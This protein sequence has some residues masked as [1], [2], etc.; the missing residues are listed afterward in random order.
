[1]A[2]EIP[3][4]IDIEKAFQDAASKIPQSIKPLQTMMDQNALSIRLHIDGSHKMM[5]KDIL[6]NATLSAS[7]LKTA[8]SDISAK[9]AKMAA[10]GGFDLTKGLKYSEKV[11]LQAYSA[12]ENK[13][14]G[15]TDA[16]KVMEK[17]YAA[18]IDKS[19]QKITQ[20]T[21]EIDKL[22]LKLNRQYKLSATKDSLIGGRAVENTKNKIALANAELTKTK[23]T[24]SSLSV[25][26]DKIS[27]G[28]SRATTSMAM[29]RT[30]AMQM[31]EEW[32]RGATYVE[33]YNA[34]LGV[35]NSRLLMLI[36]SSASL[37][38]LHSAIS[39]V[40]NVREVTSEFEMQR[41]A[42]GG[43]IQD[44]ERAEQLFKQIKAA[45]IQ[46]PFEIKDLVSFTK[47]LS[48]YR[49]ETE[50]LFDVTMK[51]AD[52]SAGLGVDMSR[53]VLAYGQVRAASVLRGQELRQFTEA[54]IPL[55]EL[56][57]KK[58][59]ELGREGTTTADVFELISKRAV[60]FSM[61]EDIFNDMTDAG[62]MFYKMQEKQ[63]ET[64]KGQWMKL[65]DALSIMYDEI[66]NTEKVHGA[67]ET[68]LK[69]AMNL[70]QNW[71]EVGKAVG[72]VV[73]SMIAYK[74]AIINARIAASALTATE[75]AEVSALQLNVVGRSRLIAA[76]FGE[77]AA[78]KAQIVLGNAYVAVKTREMMATNLFTRALYRMVAA[79][80]ANPYALAVAGIAALVAIIVKLIKNTREATISIDEFEKSLTAFDKAKSH[81]KDVNDLCDAYDKL[82]SKAERTKEEEERLAK[83]TKELARSYPSAITGVNEHTKAI[84]L[85]TKA[86]RDRN[87]AVKEAIK[88]SLQEQKE[89]AEGQVEELQ[90]EYD[91]IG[92]ILERGT[93]KKAAY[94]GEWFEPITDKQR[95]EFVARLLEIEDEMG[96][97][98]KD[99]G[100]ADESLEE[101]KDEFAGPELPD[102]FGDA[103]R[104]KFNSYIAMLD[105]G[106]TQVRAFAKDEIEGF[107]DIKAALD[108]VAKQYKAQTELVDVYTNALKTA[109]GAQKE[110]LEGLLGNATL[111]QALYAQ[112][113]TDFNA[114]DLVKEKST[115][116]TTTDPFVT[117]MKE[118]V[119][120]MQDFRKGYDDLRKYL[121]SQEALDEEG[122]LM[123]GRGTSLGLDASQQRRAADDLSQWYS[124]MIELTKE[125]MKQRG[126]KGVTVNDLLGLQISDANKQ[127]KDLQSLL[128]T[129]WDAKTDFDTDQLKKNLEKELKDL[130]DEIKRSE[131]ARNFYNNML[132]LTGDEE[133]AAS[134]SV[135]VYGGIGQDFKD[136]LQTQL[137][138]ALSKLDADKI[139][140]ELRQA[141]AEQDFTTILENLDKFPEEW[142]KDLQELAE[143]NEKYNADWYTDFVKTYQKTR[144]YEQRIDTL[145]SQRRQKLSEAT[146]MG[147]SKE[148]IDAV[149]AYYDKKIAEVQ[150]EAMKDTYTWTKAFEDL[151]GVSTLTLN[152][153]INLIDEY[154]TKYGKDLEPQQLKELTRSREQAENQIKSR[155]AYKA[156]GKAVK[157]L[158]SAY[159]RANKLSADGGEETEEYA[160]ALDDEKKAIKDLT[161]ALSEIESE[162]NAVASS[163]KDLM[164][165]FAS[166]DDAAY[167]GEQM[168]NVS[169]TLG[170]MKN[171]SAGIAQLAAGMI[172]PQAIVQTVTGL[173]DVVAGVFGA[174]NAAK[175][176]RINS[177]LKEQDLLLENLEESYTKLNEAMGKTF[178]NDYLYNYNQQL[179]NLAAKQEAY[180][181]QAQLERDKGKKADEDKI[182]EYEAS[183]R[184]A[185]DGVLE[186]RNDLQSAFTGSDLASAAESFADAWLSAYQEFGDT[187]VAIEERM[188][189]MVQNIMKKAALSGIAQNILGGWYDSLADVQDWNAQTIAEK[190]KEA[191]ALVDPMVQ[192]MQT[193]ANSMQAE[194]INLRQTAGQF[195]GI[196][197]D[198]AGASEESINGLTIGVNTAAAYM[199]HIEATVATIL[200]VLTGGEVSPV[201]AATG[202]TPDPYKD[203]MLLYASSLP[204]MRTDL[205]SIRELLSSVIKAKGSPAS[206]YV[207]TNL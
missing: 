185:A 152:N 180:L 151:D 74:V 194:G 138:T 128:Q 90:K 117:Q 75:V 165:V 205:A 35:S 38:A 130:S 190:W 186:L 203:T 204:Q 123:L 120:F 45:A 176:K 31:A 42:L 192:G 137:N 86:I 70:M 106:A 102:F 129:L 50:N 107:D 13:I 95:N 91:R 167:F 143:Q 53:L 100:E 20:L 133:L 6:D 171:A 131:T 49:I 109:S 43:I 181:K 199:S 72:V 24:L 59:Q 9:I 87:E 18:N 77:A 22:T 69:D 44:T 28:S 172:T 62:G 14:H 173:A 10:N 23:Q 155:D 154:V 191:M 187:S 177:E 52:I 125:R 92:E 83:V 61:I 202:A 101:F 142:Q 99:I 134:M 153:L 17:I 55:V 164:S 147:M 25:E 97:F 47:Q 110:Q 88:L 144:S 4:V 26:F 149:N 189:E 82:S 122:A 200:S 5:V 103:W 127:L 115:R 183:A 179:E 158:I 29:M 182:R 157:D 96:K 119:K 148:D 63:A 112:I 170:G 34:S 85:D 37:L 32:R 89:K 41:V 33:R 206:S 146:A 195:T 163:A 15:V 193:F 51:L 79:L 140:D 1:M 67:M 7:N 197:R 166:D 135:S 40:R 56:L 8:L 168:D 21:A 46:S 150:L 58:F 16:S 160:E 124:E 111:M 27:A 66:G 48:A 60:P 2:V 174:A 78:T 84:E 169:K 116:S 73:T 105:D 198:I 175:M 19:K 57:A 207:S 104:M 64:L 113:L 188:T 65:K 94:G 201:S 108:E 136:R 132:D 156:T 184:E 11:L 159:K 126:A 121:S 98:R 118:R 3:V 30:P 114:W 161:D 54:G 81:A 145:E 162:F 196:K 71:R 76:L 139:S 12:L 178:G 80:L 36:K 93:I 39:F 141:F 68:L